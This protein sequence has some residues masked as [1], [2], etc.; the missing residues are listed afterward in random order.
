MTRPLSQIREE[1]ARVITPMMREA[2]SAMCKGELEHTPF[3]WRSTRA[4]D[5]T[6]NSHTIKYLASREFC[7]INGKRVSITRKGRETLIDL[8][9][10]AA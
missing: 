5:G 10:W 7:R 9:G 1:T 8:Q 2:L 4:I 3:G 6:W